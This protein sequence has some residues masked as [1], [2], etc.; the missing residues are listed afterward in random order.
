MLNHATLSLD[1]KPHKIVLERRGRSGWLG[2]RLYL[3]IAAPAKLVSAEAKALAAKADVVLVTAGFDADSE[4]EGSDRTFDLP[5]G[6]NQLIREL[7]AAN[8]KTIVAVT[9]GTPIEQ[10]A[11]CGARTS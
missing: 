5:F 9:S 4:S 3:G 6:Q 7:A 11:V 1:L 8:K 2:P 10:S